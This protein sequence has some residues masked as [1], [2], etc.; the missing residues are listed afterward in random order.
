GSHALMPSEP[1]RAGA[2]R[3]AAVLGQL[4]VLPS[5]AIWLGVAL[6]AIVT[7]FVIYVTIKY[8]PLVSRHFET[9]PPFLPFG[10][11]PD[12][13]GEPIEFTTEDGL[14][15]C[16]SYFEGKTREQAGII[17]FC[18]EYLS[19]RWSYHP[20]LDYLRDLGFDVFTFDFRNHG[21]SASEPG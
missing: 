21:E 17:V 11:S 9:Q 1:S 16:G 18:H 14:R 7:L 6:A 4:S 19:D 15:L 20:Y 5:L 8:S 2:I 13:Q 12:E 10:V 3:S